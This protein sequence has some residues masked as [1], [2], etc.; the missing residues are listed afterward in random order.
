[1]IEFVR[2]GNAKDND[3]KPAS[4]A[5]WSTLGNALTQHNVWANKDGAAWS[6][7]T[8]APGAKRG[9]A[10]VTAI[11]VAVFDLDHLSSAQ[12]REIVARVQAT[13][14][15]FA[16]HSTFTHAPPNDCRVRLIIPLCAPIDPN[17]W[18]SYVRAQLLER[19]GNPPID[20]SAKDPARLFYLPAKRSAD[21]PKIA[22][23]RDGQPFM[24]DWSPI[25]PI[26]KIISSPLALSPEAPVPSGER[27]VENLDLLRDRLKASRNP[28]TREIRAAILAGKPLAS[29]GDQD[30]TL[31]R[32]AGMLTHA[33]PQFTLGA[34]LAVCKP[35]LAAMEWAEGFEHLC[36]EF[37]AK[38]ERAHERQIENFAERARQD[39]EI[40][41]QFRDESAIAD[42]LGPEEYTSEQIDEWAKAQNCSIDQFERRWI[43]QA[44]TAYYVFVAGR[45]RAPIPREALAVSLPRDLSRAPTIKTIET[46]TG[47][48]PAKVA[49]ILNA[50]ATV[51]RHVEAS[52]I[53][54]RSFYDA[55]TETF[56]EAICSP[57]NLEPTESSAI[58][59][60]IELLGGPESDRLI[61]WIATVDRLD[62]Q[63]CALYLQ[64]SAGT[65]KTLLATGLARI[66]T[67]GSPTDIKSVVLSDFNSAIASCPLILADEEIP[68]SR[69]ESSTSI[70]RTL[71]GTTERRLSRKFM[72]DATI[73]GAVRVI[74]TANND[75]LLQADEDL[76]ADDIDAIASRFLHIRV[77]SE[78]QRYLESIGGPPVIQR[79]WINGDAIAKHALWLKQRRK[80]KDGGRFLVEGKTTDLHA[81]LATSSGITPQVCEWI[82]RYMANPQP[83]QSRPTGAGVF[84]G[85]GKLLIATDTVAQNWDV[86]ITSTRVPTADRVGRTLR[87]ISDGS[88]RRD[89]GNKR[90][91]V[92]AIRPDLV[93]GWAQRNLVG[94]VDAIR[95][96]IEGAA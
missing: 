78:P 68:K 94:D 38:L 80:V 26:E 67:T 34:L 7:C 12:L 56:H 20:E 62:R 63:S 65:G 35:S 6:P 43:I 23:W 87:S 59:H 71:I 39:A 49:D 92:H 4:V 1:M 13:E 41:E 15:A 48:R 69:H 52:L 66:W 10:G 72:A 36:A 42:G 90:L 32:T 82:C 17:A 75:R 89:V 73:R 70:L 11:T 88:E 47:E 84:I 14:L 25:V 61:D 2:F 93:L 28:K 40:L 19:I 86:Y 30:N 21:S 58:Q 45:Y 96:R 27:T 5:D 77:G 18:A 3:P 74:I 37:M 46:K 76:S 9:N 57:R 53:L 44:G 95:A 51:A 55:S 50:H 85:E 8:Y 79:D 91:R 54:R 81:Q 22:I 24:P 60:W 31:Q 83:V 33:A 64:G 29:P 16:V